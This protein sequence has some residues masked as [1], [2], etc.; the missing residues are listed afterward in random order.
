MPLHR[1][2]WLSACFLAVLLLASVAIAGVVLVVFDF[3]G[4]AFFAAF[5]AC[6]APF[7]SARFAFFVAFF[8]AFLAFFSARFVSFSAFLSAFFAIFSAVSFA[9]VF[10]TM[11]IPMESLGNDAHNR[12]ANE[13]VAAYTAK[14]IS[15]IW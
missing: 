11:A 6:F 9:F 10:F 1:P 13:P 5:L 15:P 8:S 2:H 12:S 3:E 14:D 7:F 4:F